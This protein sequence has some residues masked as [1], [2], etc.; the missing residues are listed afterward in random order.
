MSARLNHHS[1]NEVF[2]FK[3]TTTRVIQMSL[4]SLL[5]GILL[6]R[7]GWYVEPKIIVLAALGS[8]LMMLIR[9]K[10]LFLAAIVLA[11][12]IGIWRG[13]IIFS[14]IEP[15]IARYEQKVYLVGQVQD[16]SGDAD[17]YQ[18]EFHLHKIQI[19]ENESQ[20]A[21]AG[22]IIVRGYPKGK[23]N[24]GDIVNVAGKLRPALGNNQGQI[25][26]AAVEI[27]GK[28]QDWLETLRRRFFA[29]TRSALPEPQASLG[30]GFIVGLR[31]L[32]PDSLL[33]QLTV[34]GLAHIVAVS[35]Y[36][37]TILVRFARRLLAKYSKY[38]STFISAFLIIGFLAVTGLSPS[39]FRAAI[40][41]GLSLSAWY[42]GRQM[43]PAMLLLVASA[44]TA[45]I[46]PTF[47]WYDI[48]WYLSF[49]AFFGVLVVAPS[50][51][52]RIYKQH[53]PNALVQLV[54]ESFAA[55]I[56]VIP[57]LAFVFGQ[58]SLIGFIANVIVLPLIP[59]AMFVTFVAGV[60]GMIIPA[61]AGW[62][63][64]PANIMLGFIIE[65]VR[66]LAAV[67]SA[68]KEYSV[69]RNQMLFVYAILSVY[70]FGLR[71]VSKPYLKHQRS[72]VE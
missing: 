64:W 10:Y 57:L 31:S 58:V 15:I 24:R 47:I 40:I 35:G 36:N 52:A 7:H 26:F 1:R 62:I 32:L 65:I 56:M 37:L 49:F 13:Q 23:I 28:K 42:Y 50:L 38:L 12:A 69:S 39:I 2:G 25:S 18:T 21:V 51:V 34:T 61:I 67:P 16:D 71:K 43:K 66:W 5:L 44:I 54:I 8:F 68:T 53:L 48:G 27:I 4:A 3:L 41:S 30:L 14:R 6:A 33:D 60:G 70:L 63:A 19:I 11:I 45:Y 29:G 9:S 20:I 59:L 55:Q 22:R 46:N 72:I 17:R